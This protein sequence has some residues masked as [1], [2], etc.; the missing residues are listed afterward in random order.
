MSAKTTMSTGAEAEGVGFHGDD[1]DHR[2][3]RATR[4]A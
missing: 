2:E 4:D 1:H 3:L